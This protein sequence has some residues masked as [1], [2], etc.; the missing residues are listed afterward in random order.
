MTASLQQQR[1]QMI[2]WFVK[3]LAAG[4]AGID[5]AFKRAE[6]LVN[7][8][9]KDDQLTFLANLMVRRNAVKWKRTDYEA[10][11]EVSRGVAAAYLGIME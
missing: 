3:G 2:Q 7:G 5:D 10:L 1:P 4:R 9:P 11:Y 8:I 6:R